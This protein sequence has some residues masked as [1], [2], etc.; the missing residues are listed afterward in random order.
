M[1]PVERHLADLPSIDPKSFWQVLG[2]RAIGGAIVAAKSEKGPA[3]FLGLSVTHVTQAPPTLMVSVGR[4]TSALET[5]LDAGHF[6][7]S[8][9]GIEDREIAD[10]FG[11]RTALK[12]ADRF[13]PE[14]WTALATGAPVLR[15]AVGALD[16][17]LAD[18]VERFDTVIAFG[19]I[20]A[21]M[22]NP[23]RRPLVYFRGKTMTVET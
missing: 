2:V 7:V 3:G 16:C 10:V 17:V 22:Q 6:A 8:Y 11:G 18:K 4:T 20:V 21:A 15:D 23:E 5:I 12:G 14:R 1:D 13:S 19:R 9:L